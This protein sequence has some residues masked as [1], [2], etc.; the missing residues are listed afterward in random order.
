M[1]RAVHVVLL[2]GTVLDDVVDRAREQL[3]AYHPFD[4]L[5]HRRLV[6]LFEGVPG[7]AERERGFLRGEHGLVDGAV[8]RVEAAAHRVGA[9]H[10]RRVA[11][12][13]AA[14]VDEQQLA[15]VERLRRSS[16]SAGRWR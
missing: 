6:D 5:A 1:R 7:R 16:R 8:R 13:L 15:V 11:R 14:R 3:E 9:R 4:E 12:E 2:V 10:V